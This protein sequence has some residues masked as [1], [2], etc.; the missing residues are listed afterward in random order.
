[1]EKNSNYPLKTVLLTFILGG[2]LV[3]VSSWNFEGEFSESFV[4]RVTNQMKR[5]RSNVMV[6]IPSEKIKAI[7]S[8]FNSKAFIVADGETELASQFNKTDKEFNGIVVVIDNLKAGASKDL[9]IQYNKSGEISRQ[10]PKKTQAELSSKVNGEWK[11]RE[12]I[13]GEFKN[14]DYLRV[15][16]EHKDHSWFLRYEGPGWES[17]KVGYRFYLDQRNAT[18]VFGKKVSEPVLQKVGLDGFDSYHEMQ[19]WGM[20]VMKTGKALG[21]GS[22]GMWVNNAATRVEF[23]DSVISKIDENGN[24]FSS[25]LTK[26]YG[27]KAGNEMLDVSSRLS[28]HAGTRLTNNQFD[29]SKDSENLC[30]GIVK[31]V[32]GKLFTKQGDD[33][34]WGYIASYGPQSLNKDNLGVAVLFAPKNF[35][36][37]TSDEFSQVVKLKSLDHKLQYYFLGAWEGEPGGIKTEAEFLDYLN[38]VANQLAQPV[39][40]QILKSK[41]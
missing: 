16:K 4:V 34:S 41:K 23:T 5:N 28:I 33:K 15:P 10:Y 30:T 11:G 35:S 24:V 9:T 38:D 21:V 37:F 18:D 12:Y 32:K 25:I 31:D 22:L 39:T 14:I 20:D 2:I 3:I 8:D 27:W 7:R 40:V 26:Y 13:G 1:M 19:P 6:F 17:D 36:G 29:F